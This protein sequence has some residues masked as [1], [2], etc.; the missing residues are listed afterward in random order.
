MQLAMGR[1]MKYRIVVFTFLIFTSC[2]HK[3]EVRTPDF[4]KEDHYAYVKD[5]D[6][7]MYVIATTPKHFDEAMKRLHPGPASV[8][9]LDLYVITPLVPVKAEKQAEAR[10][11][12][13]VAPKNTKVQNRSLLHLR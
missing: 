1:Y 10:A 11:N 12:T 6:G 4:V 13:N 7:R 8:D 9:K 5:D 2:V 3:T